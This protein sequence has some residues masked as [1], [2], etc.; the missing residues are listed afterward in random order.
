MQNDLSKRAFF[1]VS[2]CILVLAAFLRFYLLGEKPPHFDEGINGWFVDQMLVNGFYQYNH[3]N[4]HG[5]LY[6]YMLL[7]SQSLLGFD[8]VPLRLPAVMG[9]LFTILGIL[10]F[11]PIFG[12]KPVLVAA[13]LATISPAQVFYGRYSIHESWFAGFVVLMVLGAIGLWL[14]GAKR[15]L[16]L[17]V[18]GVTGC[19]LLKETT[20]IHVGC[21]VLAVPV[22]L[23]YTKYALNQPNGFAKREWSAKDLLPPLLLASVV[24]VLFFSG[25]FMNWRGVGSM[26]L[27]YTSWLSTGV[28]MS[29]GHEKP[30]YYWLSLF[31]QYEWP[32]AVGLAYSVYYAFRGETPTRYFVIYSCGALMAYSIVSYK[33][34]W[35]ILPFQWPFFIMCGLM[36]STVWEPRCK[37]WLA[38]LVL[39]VASVHS[40]WKMCELNWVN[41]TDP[42]EPYVYVQTSKELMVALN[43]LLLAIKTDPAARE[44]RGQVNLDSY[45][46]LPWIFRNMPNVGYGVIE[47]RDPAKYDFIIVPKKEKDKY[48]V[49]MPD[50]DGIDF[51]FRDAQAP[52]TLIVRRKLYNWV[53][54]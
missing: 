24:L 4:F 33:T 25:L 9:S 46:P 32:V 45:Y 1:V 11:R 34:P 36:V 22:C 49:L 29:S 7:V 39:A 37:S 42:K 40:A 53:R 12:A 14:Y 41:S 2:I 10:M 51:N 26:A 47:L 13:F 44:L 19:I 35:C 30:W 21:L 48:L 31:H 43:P 23:A 54:E 8:I 52:C 50:H 17:L 5:P 18:V 38:A 15:Y 28:G 16:N 20:I 27:G 6:F 3:E